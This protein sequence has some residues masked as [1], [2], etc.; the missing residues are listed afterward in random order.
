MKQHLTPPY[1]PFNSFLTALDRLAQAVPT[2]ITRDVFANASGVLRG[3]III[4]LRFFDLIDENGLPKGAVLEQLA[5][6]KSIPSRRA[7]LRRLVLSSYKEVMKF[8]LSKMS[9]AQLD[10]AF[11]R[12]HIKGDTKKKAKTFFIKAAQFAELDISPLVTSNT[13]APS[14]KKQIAA[15]PSAPEVTAQSGNRRIYERVFKFSDG[16]VATLIALGDLAETDEETLLALG[17]AAKLLKAKS[18]PTRAEASEQ[19]AALSD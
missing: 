3:Q 4:A 14:G 18:A 9:P 11:Q 7:N 2:Q 15:K 8:D 16:T 1:L 17:A 6:E 13:R 12:Y 19:A 10:T 5:K